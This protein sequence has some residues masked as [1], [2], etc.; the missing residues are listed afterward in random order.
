VGIDSLFR[1]GGQ[2]SPDFLRSTGVPE[3]AV[4]NYRRAVAE[5]RQAYYSC[6]VTYSSS[7][8]AFTSRLLLDLQARGVRC[9]SFPADSQAGQWTAQATTTDDM[10]L[11]IAEDVDRGIQYY[12]KLVAVCSGEALAVERLR[13]EITHGIQKQQTTGRWLFYPVAI[14]DEAYSRRNRYVRSLNLGRHSLFDFRRWEDPLVYSSA[15]DR[16]VAEL[17]QLR[18][19]SAGMTPESAPEG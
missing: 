8:E 6:F 14:S 4:A 3:D 10:G 7:D 17:G 16:L 1:S 18:D 13:E 5:R 11:W 9:W 15:L 2:I 19:A 12:D